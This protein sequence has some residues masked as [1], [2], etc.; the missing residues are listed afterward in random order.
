MPEK[1]YED[2]QWKAKSTDGETW[3]AAGDTIG[4]LLEW[5]H[6]KKIRSIVLWKLDD[7]DFSFWKKGKRIN[8]YRPNFKLR[9]MG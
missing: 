4:E 7:D 6:E 5:L 2:K 9:K 8:V 3:F 1:D